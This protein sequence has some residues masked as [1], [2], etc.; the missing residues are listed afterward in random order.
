M[1]ATYMS[2]LR[3]RVITNRVQP[4]IIPSHINNIMQP[5]SSS[6]YMH[7]TYLTHTSS[8]ACSCNS[9]YETRSGTA[10]LQSLSF[11]LDPLKENLVSHVSLSTRSVGI[12]LN[13]VSL[14][15]MHAD[16]TH[17]SFFCM[18]IPL[19]WIERGFFFTIKST[20]HRL[21]APP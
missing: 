6:A 20:M 7:E 15:N 4:A 5:T 18:I 13:P 8:H 21:L 12:I 2:R 11:F 9:E 3:Q 16:D 19:I 14:L 10:L 1:L 17:F